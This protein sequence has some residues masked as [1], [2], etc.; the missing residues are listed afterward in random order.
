MVVEDVEKPV[1]ER[2]KPLRAD[3]ARNREKVLQSASFLFAERGLHVTL[4][5]I[6]AHAG[7]GV[8]TVYRRFSCKEEIIDA[9][10]EISIANL[11]DLAEEAA[12]LDDAWEALIWFMERALELQAHD[13]GLRDVVMHASYGGS[14]VTKARECLMPATDRLLQRAQQ[15]GYVRKD[16]GNGDI[17]ILVMMVN[18]VAGYGAGAEPDLWRRYLAVL[19]DGISTRKAPMHVLGTP[20]EMETVEKLL[21]NPQ[22][23]KR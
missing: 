23:F 8:G 15:T 16:I 3:A 1:P 17:G 14:G 10:F 18:A 22:P 6:A 21:F 20:P 19:L 4:D 7:V 5:D 9:L 12:E 11:V 2:C 13:H